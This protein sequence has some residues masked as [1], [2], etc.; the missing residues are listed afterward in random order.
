MSNLVTPK[1]F[2]LARVFLSWPFLLPF[3]F[4]F[5]IFPTKAISSTPFYCVKQISNLIF[6]NFSK[7][8][9]VSVSLNFLPNLN[10]KF[11]FSTVSSYATA[12]FQHLL[13]VVFQHQ[14][15]LQPGVSASAHSGVSASAYATAWCFSIC[16]AL[17]FSIYSAWCSS[18]Y[19]ALVFQL[20]LQR[21]F[22]ISYSGVSASKN[23][24]E[25]KF[26]NRK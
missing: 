19:S 5:Y 9:P 12:V 25:N 10:A 21:C 18:I 15:M 7:S 1:T 26:L 24:T 20:M 8:H 22:S 23:L 17:C 3:L 14:H 4:P 2:N 13:T 16:S 6:V 11:S